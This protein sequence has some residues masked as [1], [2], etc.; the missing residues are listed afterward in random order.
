MPPY[1][2]HRRPAE[3]SGCWSVGE[4]GGP[5]GG[6][7]RPPD[8]GPQGPQLDVFVANYSEVEVQHEVQNRALDGAEEAIV[9]AMSDRLTKD[10]RRLAFLLHATM[11]RTA[12]G[13]AE[14]N[15]GVGW[16]GERPS[17]STRR[18]ASQTTCPG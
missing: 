12:Q 3:A 16:D 9:G 8:V 11:H 2:P 1:E 6:G 4:A 7:P 17:S 15:A 5:G 13:Q 14:G 18:R 10:K